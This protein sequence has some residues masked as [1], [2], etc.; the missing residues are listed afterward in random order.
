[1]SPHEIQV[2]AARGRGDAQLVR[3]L[4]DGVI[5]LHQTLDHLQALGV[6]EDP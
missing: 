1:M 3:K 4:A 2:L 6:G 5:T